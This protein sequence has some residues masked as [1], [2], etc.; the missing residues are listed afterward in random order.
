MLICTCMLVC[1]GPSAGGFGDHHIQSWW[2]IDRMSSAADDARPSSPPVN[3]GGASSSLGRYGGGPFSGY[4]CG[5]C[6]GVQGCACGRV[7]VC[8]CI[9]YIHVCV[10]VHANLCVYACSLDIHMYES[11]LH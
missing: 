6:R 10:F 4:G 5:P 9:V 7:L 1:V 8:A 11:A 2:N 3:S